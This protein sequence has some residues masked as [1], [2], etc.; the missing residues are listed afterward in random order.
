MPLF[1]SSNKITLLSFLLVAL[2]VIITLQLDKK[3]HQ[4]TPSANQPN[5]S[6]EADYFMENYTIISVA[7]NGEAFRW[8]SGKS[9]THYMNNVTDLIQP[10]L[11][12]SD[13]DQYWLLSAKNGTIEE[14]DTLAFDGDVKIHQLGGRTKALN[15]YVDHLDISLKENTASTQSKVTVSNNDSQIVA[16][17]MQIDFDNRRLRLLSNVKGQYVFD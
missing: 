7:D 17:G 6:T 5:Q 13:D 8:L 15:I 3:E 11:Q 9:L 4:A 1:V 10:T 12:F 14:R 16:T 2:T